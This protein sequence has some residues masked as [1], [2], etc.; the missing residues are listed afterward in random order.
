MQTEAKRVLINQLGVTAIYR[1]AGNFGGSK[2]WRM[3]LN[4]RFGECNFGGYVRFSP[5]YIAVK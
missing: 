5:Q 4:L 2:L 3:V 1:I